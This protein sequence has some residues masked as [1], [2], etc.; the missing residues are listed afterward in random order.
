MA[1]MKNL[2]FNVHYLILLFHSF[3]FLFFFNLNLQCFFKL[4]Q[5]ELF[6]FDYNVMLNF[7]EN[8][9]KINITLSKNE[10][11]VLLYVSL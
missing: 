10:F 9:I 2:L 11:K 1:I 7:K 3:F 8:K 4:Y 6:N 5:I